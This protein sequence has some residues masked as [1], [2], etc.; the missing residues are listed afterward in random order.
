MKLLL[1]IT[2]ILA[3]LAVYFVLNTE[4]SFS[5]KGDGGVI[6]AG[7][8][9][10]RLILN[11]VKNIIPNT[12][13]NIANNIVNKVKNPGRSNLFQSDIAS[14]IRSSV[15]EIK[16]KILEESINLV[17]DPIKNKINETFCSKD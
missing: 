9:I 8:D 15:G 7:V 14:E 17:K 16:N 13:G 2:I 10:P 1:I 11:K 5:V 3:I 4:K 12:A 6:P